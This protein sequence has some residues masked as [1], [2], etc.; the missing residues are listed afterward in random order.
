[1][2]YDNTNSNVD[3]LCSDYKYGCNIEHI[4]SS[5]MVDM[6]VKSNITICLS[7]EGKVCTHVRS[8][9]IPERTKQDV[10]FNIMPGVENI[11][12][13]ASGSQHSIMLNADGEVFGW[14]CNYS[15][16]LGISNFTFIGLTK[17]KFFDTIGKVRDIACGD[18]HT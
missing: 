11:I 14:G 2:M 3:I 17:I 4:W 13:I 16:Q 6:I 8:V 1:M 12:K 5:N 9:G 15:G 18:N 7:D 10:K